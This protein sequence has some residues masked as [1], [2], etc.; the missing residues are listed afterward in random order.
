[1]PIKMRKLHLP[2]QCQGFSQHLLGT[3]LPRHA[4]CAI[5]HSKTTRRPSLATYV[6]CGATENRNVARSHTAT[7]HHLGS[8]RPTNNLR[9]LKKHHQ[10]REATAI[11]AGSHSQEAQ[12]RSNA[13]SAKKGAT[14]TQVAARSLVVGKPY[15]GTAANTTTTNQR[16]PWNLNLLQTR[17]PSALE[18][19]S[20]TQQN[21]GAQF[22]QTQDP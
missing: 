20:A 4:R 14:E 9:S 7:A 13:T 8:A 6:T 3:T 16:L 5:S 21:A 2:C 17:S 18:S 11:G 22:N 1:M 12:G 15:P 19:A 10:S